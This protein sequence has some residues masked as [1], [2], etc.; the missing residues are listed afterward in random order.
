[1]KKPHHIFLSTEARPEAEQV[2][3]FAAGGMQARKLSFPNAYMSWRTRLYLQALTKIKSRR[4]SAKLQRAVQFISKN[5][6]Y[7]RQYTIY[8]KS[9]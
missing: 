4:N 2:F 7:N 8:L 5:N 3:S 6:L 9:T 1:M